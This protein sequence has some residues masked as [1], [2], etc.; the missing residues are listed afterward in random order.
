MPWAHPSH[1]LSDGRRGR[2]Q[3]AASAR[4]EAA[5]PC[6]VAREGQAA[7]RVPVAVGASG[8]LL[9]ARPTRPSMRDSHSFTS[10]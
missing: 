2:V 1:R 6:P 8:L 3:T 9:F 10:I 5:H 4:P 7:G